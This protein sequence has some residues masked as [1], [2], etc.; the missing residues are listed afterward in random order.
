MTAQTV[1]QQCP[2]A[3]SFARFS[4]NVAE[5]NASSRNSLR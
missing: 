3:R 1:G 5:F 4:D 2:V